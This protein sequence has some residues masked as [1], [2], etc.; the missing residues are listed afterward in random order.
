MAINAC[1]ECLKKQREID[2]LFEENQRLKQ[3]L[4]YRRRRENE[5]FFGSST[6]SAKVPVKANAT[7]TKPEKKKGAKPGHKGVGRRS[8]DETQADLVIE[9]E[10]EAGDACPLCGG[11][12]DDKEVVNRTVRETRPI[13]AQ[14]RLYRLP[15]KHCKSCRKS[16]R[17]SAPSVLPK[18][19][20]GNQL[21]STAA[22]MHYLHGIPMGRVCVLI[23]IKPGSL[24][25]IFHR[26]ARLFAGIPEKLIEQ[27]RR[28]PVRHA[29]E[30]GWRTGGKNGYAWLFATEKISIFQFRKTRSS[31]VPRA[32]FGE[33]R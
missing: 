12:L 32:V 15:G 30:T 11:P 10:A 20:Y 21:I 29:D 5:G 14:K 3:K 24:V 7:A 31:S 4:R 9:L 18:S 22:V 25:H 26:L 13:K 6:P 2:R 27:Y 19:L 33:K 23:D 1:D 28:S 17:P 8:F 16:F